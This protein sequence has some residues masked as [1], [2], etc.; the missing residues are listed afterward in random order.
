M[1]NRCDHSNFLYVGG[2]NCFYCTVNAISP[3]PPRKIDLGP[4]KGGPVDAANLDLEDGGGFGKVD[5]GAFARGVGI[6]VWVLQDNGV[7]AFR[8]CGTSRLSFK[9]PQ[10]K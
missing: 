6:V 5:V 3:P 1:G 8:R 10:Y 7:L 4:R 2:V 9:L